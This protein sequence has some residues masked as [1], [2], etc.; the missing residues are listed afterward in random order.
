TS[1]GGNMPK[2]R[3]A[4]AHKASGREV[5]FTT[6]AESEQHA[7]SV[8]HERGVLVNAIEPVAATRSRAEKTDRTKKPTYRALA[9]AASAVSIGG[10]FVVITSQIGILAVA[11]HISANRYDAAFIAALTWISGTV[12]GMF[13]VLS[14]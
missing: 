4:G 8:A 9:F 5:T 10:W 14:S 13:F 11:N 2:F 12:A 1:K 3:I 7:E 6:D